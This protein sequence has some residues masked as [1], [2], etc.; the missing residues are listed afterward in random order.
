MQQLQ[1]SSIGKYSFHMQPR[2][3]AYLGCQAGD[4]D[5]VEM[6]VGEEETAVVQAGVGVIAH[7]VA[8]EQRRTEY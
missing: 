2:D 7:H 4:E 6:E 3:A 8:W 1:G 5:I